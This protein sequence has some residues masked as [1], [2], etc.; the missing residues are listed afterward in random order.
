MFESDQEHT[1]FITDRGSI[2]NG[3]CASYFT[4]QAQGGGM[5]TNTYAHIQFSLEK[6]AC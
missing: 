2:V 3:P 5:I 4:L 1:S 6:G